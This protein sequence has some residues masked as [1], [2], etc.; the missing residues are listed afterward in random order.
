MRRSG[1]GCLRECSILFRRPIDDDDAAVAERSPATSA[2]AR[3]GRA[4]GTTPAERRHDA[5]SGGRPGGGRWVGSG[6]IGGPVSSPSRSTRMI[7]RDRETLPVESA[8]ATMDRA[9]FLATFR[10]VEA[11][12]AESDDP[13]Q[14]LKINTL[15]PPAALPTDLVPPEPQ[16][17]G[18]PVVE[19]QLEGQPAGRASEPQRQVGPPGPEGDRRAWPR[20]RQRGA[21]GHPQA[22]GRGGRPV[23]A[24]GRRAGR[25]AESREGG[26]VVEHLNHGTPAGR[27][28]TPRRA[29][30]RPHRPGRTGRGRVASGPQ[31]RRPHRAGREPLVGSVGPARGPDDRG[32]AAGRP[33]AGV[34]AGARRPA[35]GDRW[36]GRSIGRA[37]T[38]NF[39]ACWTGVGGDVP[40]WATCRAGCGR[41]TPQATI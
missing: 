38:C 18:N 10:S 4:A 5:P 35:R 20:E 3:S 16:P 32:T 13:G 30:G 24:R 21:L 29:G 19:L 27:R 41:L 17:A 26:D 9:E 12:H 11:D 39:I 31:G 33:S 7:G 6:R 40:D 8:A 1:R 23:P 37:S 34:G 22:G 36:R 14:G 28:Q 15:L 2:E 25:D